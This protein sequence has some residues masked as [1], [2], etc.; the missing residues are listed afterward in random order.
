MQCHQSDEGTCTQHGGEWA[1]GCPTV[2]VLHDVYAERSRQFARYGT[3]ADLED[4]TGPEARWMEYTDPNLDLRSAKEIE[5]AF[6]SEYNTHDKPTWMHL[7]RE[8]VAEAFMEADGQRLREELVQV[9]AL[10]VSWVE[11]LDQRQPRLEL[12][13]E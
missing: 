13:G 8:E 10:C 3:N 1:N 4:G 12:E 6:R 5:V 9:A 11:K 2:R 7:I